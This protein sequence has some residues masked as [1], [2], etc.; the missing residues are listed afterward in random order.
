GIIASELPE[1]NCVFVAQNV[2]SSVYRTLPS[3]DSI[4]IVMLYS[5]DA[6]N[7]V[8]LSLIPAELRSCIEYEAVSY[9][10]RPPDFAETISCEGKSCKVIVNLMLALKRLYSSV[11]VIYVFFNPIF[12]S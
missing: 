10:W 5:D 11:F 8:Q 6:D 12:S 9:V 2:D 1:R 4:H 7:E 3:K